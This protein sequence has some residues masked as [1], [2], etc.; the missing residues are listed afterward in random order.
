M[1]RTSTT[2]ATANRRE[3]IFKLAFGNENLH[4]NINY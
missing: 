1:R 4:E 2:N 3:D